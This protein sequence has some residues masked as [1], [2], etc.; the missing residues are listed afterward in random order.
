MHALRRIGA[1]VAIL[2]TLTP[3]CSR[4]NAR[5]K[6]DGRQEIG[7]SEDELIKY[8]VWWREYATLTSHN[9]A[10]MKAV[11]DRIAARYSL[12]SSDRIAQDPELVAMLE[13]QQVAARD[14]EARAPLSRPKMEAL[15]ETVA[16]IATLEPKD[17]GVV[18]VAGHNEIALASARSKYGDEFVDWVV[19]RE[20][21]VARVLSQ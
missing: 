17:G 6:P 19:A 15:G 1:V 8:L 16:G 5:L 21:L 20:S 3:S 13:R 7:I 10:E 11:S 9:M 4:K 18:F 12:G 14:I 2:L